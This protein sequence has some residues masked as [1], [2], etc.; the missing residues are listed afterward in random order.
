MCLEIYELHPAH[1]F[2]E[3][4]LPWRASIKNAKKDYTFKLK[5]ILS[6]VG[7]SIR[8]AISYAIAQYPKLITN[9]WMIV[10]K[11]KNQIILNIAI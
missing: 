3:S 7:E 1:F 8:G 9:S 4:G 5:S 11:I 2:T 10:I 6:T